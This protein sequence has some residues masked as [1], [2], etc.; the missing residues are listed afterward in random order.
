[1]ASAVG[2]VPTREPAR[3]TLTWSLISR[4][5]RSL[6]EMNSTVIPPSRSR[7]TAANRS[8]VS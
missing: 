2:T 6:C 4:T 7:R 8:S 1:M 5:S 3:I